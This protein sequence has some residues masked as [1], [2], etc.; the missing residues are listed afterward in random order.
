[1]W[2]RFLGAALVCGGLTAVLAG[3]EV[4]VQPTRSQE[5]PLPDGP[6]EALFED[7]AAPGGF[8]PEIEPNNTAGTATA[9]GGA[10]VQ[11]TGTI[12]PGGDEDW[13][14]FSGTAGDRVYVGLQTAFS[15]E[16]VNGGNSELRL[17]RPNGQ[18]LVEF[19]QDDGFFNDAGS[20]IA[21]AALQ[22]SGTYFLQVKHFAPTSQLRPYYL[23]FRRM[24]G[25]PT[26]ESEPNDSPATAN[27]LPASGWVSGI[28]SAFTDIDTYAIG[29]GAG[30]TVFLSLDLDPERN[31]LPANG[32]WDGRLGFGLFGDAGDQILAADDFSTPDPDNPLSE[33][34]FMT[35]KYAGT[36]YVT[37]DSTFDGGPTATYRLAASVR[38]AAPVGV[39][40]QTYSSGEVNLPIGPLNGAV[41]N[42]TLF[43]PG[44]PR[45]E[46]LNVSIVLDHTEMADVDAALLSPAGNQNSLFTDVGAT[47]PGGQ[48]R[49][50]LDLDDEAG[51]PIGYFTTLKGMAFQPEPDYRLAWFKG[52]DG[53]GTWTLRLRDDAGPTRGGTLTSWSLTLCQPPPQVC[54][55]TVVTAYASSFEG[56]ADG[57]THSGTQDEWARG[58]PTSVP[59]TGCH[60]GTSCWKT[61]LTGNYNA[62]SNQSLLSPN[63]A[64]TGMTKPIVV[65]WAQKYQMENASFDTFSVEVRE[66]GPVNATTLFRHLDA[67]MQDTVG[68]PAAVI[69][70]SA[71][72]GLVTRRIDAYANKTIQLQWNLVSDSSL[73]Y[74][75]LAVDDVVVTGCQCTPAGCDDGNP[76]TV[77]TCDAAQGCVHT[78][79]T[80]SCEDGNAC[81]SSDTCVNGICVGTPVSCSDGDPCTVDTCSPQ[82]GCLFPPLDCSD[83]NPCTDDGCS[84]GTCTHT[85]NTLSCSDG[86]A[87]TVDDQ[88]GGGACAG[89]PLS[90]DDG[91]ACTDDGCDPGSGCTYAAHS[92]DDGD[93][94][95]DDGC[96]AE[97]GC[98]HAAHSCDDGNACTD[99]GCNPGSG[100]TYAAHSCDDGNPCTDD[101]CD[102]VTGCASV[103]NTGSCEDGN[104]CTT[105]DT[106][107]SGA[108][109]GGSPMSCDDGNP[110]TDDA[111]DPATGCVYTPHSCDDGNPCTDDSCDVLTGCAYAPHSCDDGNVCTDD[112]CDPAAGCAYTPHSCD[113]GNACT[114][115]GCSPGT[116][117]VSTV[118]SCDDGDPCT[119]DSCSPQT[120]CG[121]TDRC[122][123]HCSPGAITIADSN[124]PPTQASPYP[125][126]LSVSGFVG[127]LRVGSV[128]LLGFGHSVPEEVDVLLVGPGGQEA[129]ILSDVGGTTAS[130]G[131]DLLLRDTAATPLP[132]GGGLVSGIFLPTNAPPE[133]EF[134]GPAPLPSGGSALSRFTGAT[135]NG[136]WQLYVVDD[137]YR[138]AGSLS[139]GWCLDLVPACVTDADCSDG[140][141]C[142][143]DTCAGGFCQNPPL[144]CDD[145]NACTDDSCAPGSGCQ[146]AAI[147]CDD[148][149]PCTDDSCSAQSGCL[150]TPHCSDGSLCTEDV[151]EPGT[152]SC[153]W[154]PVSCEDGNPCTDDTCDP[155]TGCSHAPLVCDD[156]DACTV[157]LCD[158]QTGCLVAPLSCDDGNACT[159]DTCDSQTGCKHPAHLCD[160]GDPCTDDACDPQSGCVTAPHCNDGD[161]CTVDACEAG[162]G[163]CSTTPLSCDDGN[164]C[165]V[166]S[167]DPESGCQT[168]PLSCDDGDPC[169]DDACDPLSGCVTAPHCNDGDACTVDACEVGTG[170]CSTT[171]LSCDDGN[172]CTVDSCDPQSGCQTAPLSCEDGN[173]C[174]DDSCDSQT[175]CQQQPHLCDDGDP[176]TDDACDPQS[177]CVTAPH[178]NDGDACT[179]DACEAGTGS[180]STTPISCED[181]DACTVDSCDPQSGCQTAPLSCD[182][183]DVCTEDACDPVTGCTT[184]PLGPPGEVTGLRFPSDRQT[185]SWDLASAAFGYDV[186]RGDLTA[187]P[188]GSGVDLC[189]GAFSSTSA[190][191]PQ[192]PAEEAGFW[193][194]V[195]GTN[196]CAGAGSYG[197]ATGGAPRVTAACP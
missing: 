126:T 74:A 40:C 185:L 164:P 165:T 86:S 104:A 96:D 169:T 97:T 34:L 196:T 29:L 24:S 149:D 111:C 113:D 57:F 7:A 4:A 166:D 48:T 131:V 187:F 88:C 191:D 112:A 5:K 91:N 1:M 49:M 39:Q 72:W 75:G 175:G 21:G 155:Q 127:N 79:R 11:A 184:T 118:D 176:C 148:G 15:S 128:R 23:Y 84:G 12:L 67:T 77:D 140:N 153:S 193:Y 170:S 35:V 89:T 36:Y 13:W 62:G 87:C 18:T 135:A 45:I 47:A 42:S 116:G 17:Y 106:C 114:V 115:D 150:T 80:G 117:C 119:E 60:T 157:D 52:E 180:C 9:L 31:N 99:D 51:I 3:T 73:F 65:T 20:G 120:G 146:H 22:T 100:C 90:C 181:G 38:H 64:L 93:A 134:P 151:C 37:V 69:N 59:V 163:S 107:S 174:T 33:T 125:S 28:H 46:D 142:T 8:V 183:G 109:V 173:P 81:T 82:S 138:S 105:A 197:D 122:S 161:A 32:G 61:D 186:A 194:L 83:G 50:D 159:D 192:E 102:P 44:N 63:I 76:C 188:V 178:C 14:S 27:P 85:N 78:I 152:G 108:C 136:T 162:T 95:T 54:E 66:P 189:L 16:L 143:A 26:A 147:S 130:A 167:C 133:D 55:G 68:S 25:T 98:Q 123:R 179:V 171:P 110:C 168:A 129:T 101:G 160:D 71:G 53:G 177:G 190:S 10:D 70:E 30:D 137:A 139:G 195:R 2:S 156:G 6:M 144:S 124:V 43:V 141:A 121:H 103:D 94:C 19:D 158:P 56:G 182:D 58:N 92:C 145:G 41:T 154:V 132:T 172:A